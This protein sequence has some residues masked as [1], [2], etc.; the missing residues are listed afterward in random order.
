NDSL[1]HLS[2]PE[3]V[4]YTDGSELHYNGF[5]SQ[6]N[7]FNCLSILDYAKELN[8]CKFQ[9]SIA[10][11]KSKHRIT[12]RAGSQNKFLNKWWI[13]DCFVFETSIS[14]KGKL[15]HFILFSGDWFQIEEN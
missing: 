4:N 12:A 11:V 10:E 15:Q 13:Y 7:T 1:L 3:I 6:G 5:G 14:I 8:R 2:P 9:G